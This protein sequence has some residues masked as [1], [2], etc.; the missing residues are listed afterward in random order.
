M[1]SEFL[2]ASSD[3]IVALASGNPPAGV[4]VLRLSGGAAF[5]VLQVLTRP[6]LP[7]PRR[8]AMRAL[9]DPDTGELLDRALAVRFVAPN[10][11]TGEDTVELHLHGG[12]AIVADTLAAILRQPHCRQAREGEFTRRAFDH[13]KLDLTAVEGLSDLVRARTAAQRRQALSAAGGE[14]HRTLLDWRDRLL[15]ARALTETLIDFVDEDI[16]DDLIGDARSSVAAVAQAM[17]A[18][19]ADADAGFAVRDGLRV[20]IV[21]A[22]N[23]GKSTL[24]NALA[25]REAAIVSSVAGTTRDVVEITLD[26]AGHLVIIADTAGLRETA[27]TIEAEGV[28][29]AKAAMQRADLCIEVRDLSDPTAMARMAD[30]GLPADR[31]VVFWNKADLAE[32]DAPAGA[33]AGAAATGCGIDAL[34][35]LILDTARAL[36]SRGEHAV[37]QRTRHQ[38]ALAAAVDALALWEEAGVSEEILASALDHAIRALDQVVGA[39]H[40][41]HMLDIIFREF[42]IGK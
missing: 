36:A 32:R 25:G 30:D 38:T 2:S 39:S 4:A 10:S 9:H 6:P 42:C 17:R 5:A 41:E 27:D 1:P 26:L 24:L 40:V 28:R 15:R 31:T 11:F 8:M 14:A 12:P 7:E 13:G 20:A 29:R 22:P 3:T 18:A 35:Q 34:R 21:G 19:L 37:I 23:V 16:P 33:L